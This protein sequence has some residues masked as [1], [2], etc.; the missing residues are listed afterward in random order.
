MQAANG[1]LNLGF[2]QR[3]INSKELKPNFDWDCDYKP[4]ANF[5]F[6]GFIS[7]NFKIQDLAVESIQNLKKIGINI[8]L[9]SSENPILVDVICKIT[10]LTSV[11]KVIEGTQ[12]KNIK[13]NEWDDIIKNIPIAIARGTIEDKKYVVNKLQKHKQWIALIGQVLEDG[14][15]LRC[16]DVVLSYGSDS[17]FYSKM[18][19]D[20][21]VTDNNF[22]TLCH[23]FHEA[24]SSGI[25]MSDI[26]LVE[27]VNPS[28]L[29]NPNDEKRCSIM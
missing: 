13:E 20:I 7:F 15:I 3:I 14:W 18:V 25:V 1:L 8:L 6:L 2:C 27:A 21:H 22:S 4:E 17:T 10:N 12:I 24:K 26:E 19:A 23:S 29:L 9:Y 11:E 28:V 16:A 5:C